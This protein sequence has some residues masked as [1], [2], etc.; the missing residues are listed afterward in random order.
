MP[1]AR[2]RGPG[3]GTLSPSRGGLET[4]FVSVVCA[5]AKLIAASR[6]AVIVVV[7]LTV[8]LFE[9]DN[10]TFG[11]KGQITDAVGRGRWPSAKTSRAEGKARHSVRAG[12]AFERAAGRGLP[13][14]PINKPAPTL[15]QIFHPLPAKRGEG[16]G[17]GILDEIST[18][19]PKPQGW[20]LTPQPSSGCA[21]FSRSR[22]RRNFSPQLRWRRGRQSINQ[23]QHRRVLRRLHHLL[24]LSRVA[25]NVS[26]L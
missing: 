15:P 13:A 18:T 10:P 26:S 8:G 9:P 2:S 19:S 16:R 3:A 23:H 7:I 22:E 5:P 14:L 4:A 17:E 24:K 20:F 11:W 1:K 6:M 21:T 12:F 25:A